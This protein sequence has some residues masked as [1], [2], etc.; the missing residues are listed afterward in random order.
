[1]GSRTL[2]V[3]SNGKTWRETD[4]DAR[5]VVWGNG[6]FVAATKTRIVS[7]ANGF[8]WN[9]R[10]E[11]VVSGIAFGNGR[12]VATGPSGLVMTSADGIRWSRQK[13]HLRGELARVAFGMGRFVAVDDGE[14][15]RL[16]ASRDGVRWSVVLRFESRAEAMLLFGNG[17]FLLAFDG[18]AFVSRDGLHWT[19]M[20]NG[21][22]SAAERVFY[23]GERFVWLVANQ[24]MVQSL[25]T[26]RDLQSWT[27]E[28]TSLPLVS[29]MGF[30]D[31]RFY[32]SDDYGVVYGSTDLRRWETVN[33]VTTRNLSAV[34]CGNG[35]LVAV[36]EGGT[37]LRSQDA[38]TWTAIEP[39][40]TSN[41]RAVVNWKGA[42]IA[43]GDAGALFRSTDGRDWA[44]VALDSKPNI[45]DLAFTEDVVVAVGS[46]TLFSSNGTVWEK[47]V[48][49]AGAYLV[50]A[51]AGNGRIVAIND[52][53]IATS[54][55]GS[56]WDKGAAPW[57]GH[58]TVDFQ[59][60]LFHIEGNESALA[61][62]DGKWWKPV[63]RAPQ[64]ARMV[65]ATVSPCSLAGREVRVGE[66]GHIATRTAEGARQG[67]PA[68]TEWTYRPEAFAARVYVGE[69]DRQHVFVMNVNS[70]GKSL[71]GSYRYVRRKDSLQVKGTVSADG[72]FEL[73]E[74]TKDGR[75]TGS[76]GG[77]LL[78]NGMVGQW[79][80]PDGSKVLY[81]DGYQ[82]SLESIAA[83]Q[84]AFK[85]AFRDTAGEYEVTTYS[86]FEG[87]NTMY[88]CGK[89]GKEWVCGASAIEQ[90][91]RE[92]F[93]WEVPDFL[94]D[95][96]Y[97][98]EIDR[99]LTISL[100]VNRRRVRTIAVEE[101]PLVY[102]PTNTTLA[103]NI[104]LRQLGTEES[105]GRY[106]LDC[107]ADLKTFTLRGHAA[108]TFEKKR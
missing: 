66:H 58:R 52:D 24:E 47:S 65:G 95:H 14:K 83:K 102:F 104:P 46:S 35:W 17:G 21:D 105:A 37:V 19:G 75:Q 29:R 94:V 63:P 40:T 69:M 32:A 11:A 16:M 15:P 74:S 77:K 39:V 62:I 5:E 28:D 48:G 23:V 61:S 100:V 10:F 98:I 3:S 12:F 13:F 71:S 22:M 84:A 64:R 1:M 50:K 73:V 59:D 82:S 7:S 96:W 92:P 99:D 18:G 79:R 108:L 38:T 27:K 45:S 70:D 51:A 2:V 36:G 55:D 86:D 93:D 42:F 25:H 43:A 60:G 9:A 4:I 34:T 72:T 107:S 101:N 103:K 57:S 54:A 89:Q 41:L 87:A 88:D 6:A 91:R 33:A 49:D 67:R 76:L 90:G 106:D 20:D 8:D 53:V 81:V 78:G 30:V 26:S 68:E 85:S 31:G 44:R 97:R 80:A 56:S